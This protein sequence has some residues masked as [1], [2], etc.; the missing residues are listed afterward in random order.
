MS[1]LL[2]DSGNTNLKLAQVEANSIVKI[3]RT[4]VDKLDLGGAKYSTI[5]ISNT[6]R[7]YSEQTLKSL[8]ANYSD[9]EIIFIKSQVR[10]QGLKNAYSVPGQ[11]GTDRWLNLIYAWHN[12]KRECS[13][14]SCG[15]FITYDELSANGEHLG[16]LIIPGL[17]FTKN[18]M[19]NVFKQNLVGSN[20]LQL[21]NNTQTAIENGANHSLI[22]IVQHLIKL[23]PDNLIILTGGNTSLLES[24][25]SPDI[26]IIN[27][28]PLKGLL[29]IANSLN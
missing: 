7:N 29:I 12:F 9:G 19:Q 20:S 22:A 2:V 13:I 5:L 14:I 28:L 10:W 21:A 1:K 4:T 18:K 27:N 23:K 15:T 24:Y 11:L 3:I 6:N 8:F 16:G 25:L 26:K 17:N